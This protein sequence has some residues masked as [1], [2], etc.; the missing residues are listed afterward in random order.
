MMASAASEAYQ[1]APTADHLDLECE[2]GAPRSAV[3]TED[4]AGRCVT[5]INGRVAE[6]RR[7]WRDRFRVPRRF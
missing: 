3:V 4:G 7:R 5:C 2:C 6:L 1:I